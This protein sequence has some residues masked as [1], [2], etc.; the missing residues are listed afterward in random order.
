MLLSP[1]QEAVQ[2]FL[3]VSQMWLGS[4]SALASS[5]VYSFPGTAGEINCKEATALL[6]TTLPSSVTV[7]RAEKERISLDVTKGNQ[8]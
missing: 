7:L 2:L 1:P 3:G 4:G 6:G 8:L 5:L